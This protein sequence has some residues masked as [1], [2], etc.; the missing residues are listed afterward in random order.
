MPRVY[1]TKKEV[2]RFLIQEFC[3]VLGYSISG[4]VWRRERPDALLTLTQGKN[5]K[6]IALEHTD[7]FNDTLAG[8]RSPRTP[9]DEFWQRVQASLVSRLSRR[10]HLIG[11]SA[12]VRLKS[13][14]PVSKRDVELARRLAAELIG[15]AESHPLEVGQI[16]TWSSRDLREYRALQSMV[17]NMILSRGSDDGV[18]A[19]RWSWLCSNTATGGVGLSLNYIRSAIDRKNKKSATYDWPDADEKWLLIAASGNTI[20]NCAAPL[21]RGMNWDDCDVAGLCAVSPFDRIVFWERPWSWYKWLK[22][23]EPAVEYGSRKKK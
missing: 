16:L 15:F 4:P 10:K 21:M 2:E 5:K 6:R 13:N 11:I 14:L 3:H 17:T 22:P 8:E 18:F 7:Y 23:V 19:S 9:V 20:S 1:R 12:R